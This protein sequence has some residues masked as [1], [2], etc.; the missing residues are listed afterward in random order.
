MTLY[1]HSAIKV[2]YIPTPHAVVNLS[3]FTLYLLGKRVGCVVLIRVWQMRLP[4]CSSLAMHTS[5]RR[6]RSLLAQFHAVASRRARIART[7]LVRTDLVM[8]I[9]R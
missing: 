3:R 6:A 8:Q 7:G 1:F 4:R 2:R 5:L 9:C